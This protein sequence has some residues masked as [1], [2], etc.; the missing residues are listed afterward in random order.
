VQQNA[1]HL[2]PVPSLSHLSFLPLSPENREYE[3]SRSK[4]NKSYKPKLIFNKSLDGLPE[5][6]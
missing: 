1:S 6:Q 3:K 2:S 5:L 4:S